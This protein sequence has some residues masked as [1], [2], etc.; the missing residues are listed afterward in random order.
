MAALKKDVNYPIDLQQYSLLPF[1]ID[2]EVEPPKL[3]QF[4]EEEKE[5]ESQKEKTESKAQKIEEA[6]GD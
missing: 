4:P 6:K 5:E 2:V 1:R 3:G